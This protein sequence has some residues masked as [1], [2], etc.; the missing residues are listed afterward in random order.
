MSTLF[1]EDPRCAA[2]LEF[3]RFA[4][5]VVARHP[6]LLEELARTLDAPFTEAAMREALDGDLDEE[7]LRAGLRK[8]RNRVMLRVMARDLSGLGSLE[9]V[10]STTSA[11]AEVAIQTAARV[12]DANLTAVH[13]APL[14]AESGSAQELIVIGMGKLGARELNVSS[15]IDVVFVY[16]EEGH[17]G[18]GLSNFEYFTRLARKFI[19]AL[20]EMTADG[21]VF[22]V[23][24]RLRPYGDS[25]PLVA[26]L[27]MLENYLLTQG[28]EWERFAWIKARMVAGARE[29][30]L[31]E[32]VLPFVYRRHLDY[33]VFASVRE[34]HAQIRRE[35]MRR[36]ARNNI[37]TGTGGIRAIEFV[38]QA[39]QLIR[40]GRDPELRERSTL[41]VLDKLCERGLLPEQAVSDLT[42]AYRFLRNLEHRLQYLDDQQT[43]TLPSAPEDQALI[44]RA[45]SYPNYETFALQL[46]RMR[47]K[48][49][50][51]FETVFAAS[52]QER[53]PHPLTPLWDGSLS[54]ENAQA[55]LAQLGYGE[56]KAALSHVSAI[57]RG[58]HYQQ[59]LPRSKSRLERL[60]PALIEEAAK[61]GNP[62]AT[63]ERL[64]HLI[65]A[66]GRREAYL[67][68][69]LEYPQVTTSLARLV[70]ASPWVAEYLAVHPILL[71]EFIDP[72]L[73]HRAPDW[74]ELA[75]RLEAEL[76]QANGDIE[77]QMDILRHFKHSRV[78]RLVTQDL[79]GLL[80]LTT[81]S[82]HLSALADVVLA[83]TIK[84]C[85]A[86]LKNRHSEE[87]RFAAI[88]YG[89]LGGRELGYASD[90]DLV[91][92]YDDDLEGAP[93]AYAR[94]ASRMISWLTT[95]TPAGVLYDT[96]L[97]L[98]PSGESGLLVSSIG[99]FEQ[100]QRGQAWVWEHQA[101]TRA[102]F[103]AGD[104]GVGQKF[105]TIREQVLRRERDL[106]PLAKEIVEMR[107]KMR[108]AHPN[109]S[110]LFDVKHDRGGIVDVEFVVQYLVLGHAS[111]YPELTGNIGNLALLRLAARLNLVPSDVAQAAH[112]AYW[113]MRERQHAL[114]LQGAK[115]ARVDPASIAAHAQAVIKLWEAVLGRYSP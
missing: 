64:L 53:A 115:Y 90:L 8:L 46:S 28:R 16:P 62:D 102:R 97:R 56:P 1:I 103:C 106:A 88:G 66:V 26:S 100:Y 47:E 60:I 32:L 80:P 78:F 105:E 58:R 43:Q 109:R 76:E 51:Y 70:S 7:R 99:A 52:K 48:V 34:V 89:K 81:L 31:F 96:D 92:L 20:D 18:G 77:R 91:F 37:K 114:R 2:C 71:D 35:A 65:E 72:R 83:E 67:A 42:E 41:K 24:A 5:R 19:L 59:M 61:L 9:E 68:L 29:T 107:D 36:A 63:L 27:P 108:K 110:G 6:E 38:A 13:G 11:L 82:D 69:L 14:C 104:A 30:E 93:E 85:W 112:D 45:M 87:P 55:R 10:V 15:D 22:R 3:S 86:N 57:R 12:L 49:A 54:E 94:L 73:L 23:D 111:R 74:P 98:R 17:T 21:F 25:G 84:R 39:L 113:E 40:G 44:A 33:S 4:R 79:A 101:L 75:A 50:H 95:L